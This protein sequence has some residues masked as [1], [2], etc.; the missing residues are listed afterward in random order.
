MACEFK[1]DGCGKAAP[2]VMGPDRA[3]HK[4]HNWY[5]RADGDGVQ[6]ACSRSCIERIAERTGKTKAVLPFL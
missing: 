6:D 5:Q 3:W 1:C 4:P 2:A